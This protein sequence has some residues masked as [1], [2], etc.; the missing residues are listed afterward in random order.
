ME[1]EEYKY[2]GHEIR[3][4]C[5]EKRGP[6]GELYWRVSIKKD[7]ELKKHEP[8]SKPFDTYERV[9]LE[10]GVRPNLKGWRILLVF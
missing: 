7:G 5:E 8:G 1:M 10:S 2:K 4:S 6:D 3:V 9:K